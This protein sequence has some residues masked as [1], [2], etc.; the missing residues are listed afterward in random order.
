MQTEIQ[1][2]QYKLSIF[3]SG[4][5]VNVAVSIITKAFMQSRD[6][7]RKRSVKEQQKY[8]KV[9]ARCF[10]FTTPHRYGR[11]NAGPFGHQFQAMV[12]AFA[13]PPEPA[14]LCAVG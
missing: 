3:E 10:V 8:A 14:A 13:K 6:S 7:C 12:R 11:P 5:R 2:S 1:F 9:V 4:W